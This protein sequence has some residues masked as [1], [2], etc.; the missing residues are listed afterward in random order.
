M[1][2]GDFLS[3]RF[4]AQAADVGIQ[5]VARDAASESDTQKSKRESLKKLRARD[6]KVNLMIYE[7][8]MSQRSHRDLLEMKRG[9]PLLMF[10]SST[11]LVG[12]VSCL[13]IL[14]AIFLRPISFMIHNFW[15]IQDPQSKFYQ[16][17]E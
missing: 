14:L 9:I 2:F 7:P 10:D 15:T 5:L 8:W 1:A 6:L 17:C 13:A 12:R 16:S 3:N 4:L 11:G